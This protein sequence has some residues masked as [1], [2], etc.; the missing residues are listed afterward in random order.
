MLGE[1]K[2]KKLTIIVKMIKEEMKNKVTQKELAE[3]IREEFGLEYDQSTISRKLRS[4][5]KMSIPEFIL[6]TEAMGKPARKF[7]TKSVVEDYLKKM[8]GGEKGL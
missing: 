8:K 4:D 5:D 3:V 6:I 2:M 1:G 7:L